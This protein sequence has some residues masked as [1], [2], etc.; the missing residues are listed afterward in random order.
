MLIRS[1]P[2]HLLRNIVAT[3]GMLMALVASMAVVAEQSAV[4]GSRL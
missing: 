1:D 2:K 3:I 4:A